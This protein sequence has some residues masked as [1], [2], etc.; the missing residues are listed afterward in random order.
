[1]A[2]GEAGAVGAKNERNMRKDGWHGTEGAVEQKLLG[3][4]GN[5]IG[6][7][8]YVRDAHVDVVDYGAELI[9]GQGRSTDCASSRTEQHEILDLLVLN[10]ARAEDG[11]V[12]AGGGTQRHA[13]AHRGILRGAGRH[14]LAARAAD[15]PPN[16]VFATDSF[17]REISA[18]V[19]FRRTIAEI[20]SSDGEQLFRC[21]SVTSKALGLIQRSLIPIEAQPTQAIED[22]L[23]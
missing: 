8:N 19:F 5:V 12:Q 22:A 21:G 1:M 9:G 13:E 2:L 14:A 4:I 11:V 7:A 18:R 6:A 17:V 10:F 15:N 16:F 3:R 23:D 20:G